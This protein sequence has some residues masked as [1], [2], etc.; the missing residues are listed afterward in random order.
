MPTAEVGYH[1]SL[2]PCFCFPISRAEGQSET[3]RL[4]LPVLSE[5]GSCDPGRM[6]V[7]CWQWPCRT[8]GS[9]WR[10]KF[11]TWLDVLR[12]SKSQAFLT[13]CLHLLKQN[14]MICPWSS[15][16]LRRCITFRTDNDCQ[17][18]CIIINH[19]EQRKAAGQQ[20]LHNHFV[21]YF[22]AAELSNLYPE[23]SKRK[24]DQDRVPVNIYEAKKPGA[25]VLPSAVKREDPE[26]PECRS[27][28]TQPLLRKSAKRTKH[29]WLLGPQ[30]AYQSSTTRFANCSISTL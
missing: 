4:F 17:T 27:V 9:G 14:G 12:G 21:I 26:C 24:S 30:L 2:S 5:F 20:K 22:L 16:L 18:P 3:W 8:R 25:V 29:Q 1:I 6:A 11:S 28:S 19:R 15:C 13:Q 10:T 7:S 23:A